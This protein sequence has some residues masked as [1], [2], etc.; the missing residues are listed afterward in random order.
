MERPLSAASGTSDLDCQAGRHGVEQGTQRQLAFAGQQALKDL[1]AHGLVATRQVERAVADLHAEQR[2]SRQASDILRCA[3][4][5]M[6]VQR[7]DDVADI[8]T[9]RTPAQR[10]DH[11]ACWSA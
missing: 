10:S 9:A 11:A 3:A 6:R 4:G 8:R 7:V 2:F 5:A 1:S